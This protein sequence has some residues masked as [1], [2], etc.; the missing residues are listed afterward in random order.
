MSVEIY[1]KPTQEWF[2]GVGES[3]IFAAFLRRLMLLLLED[4]QQK[5]PKQPQAEHDHVFLQS[6]D[7][8]LTAEGEEQIAWP[9]DKPVPEALEKAMHEF[10]GAPALNAQRHVFNTGADARERGQNSTRQRHL[11]DLF[12]AASE[13]YVGRHPNHE[14][15]PHIRLWKKEVTVENGKVVESAIREV[16]RLDMSNHAI[17]RLPGINNIHSR[18]DKRD[19]FLH[20]TELMMG[21]DAIYTAPEKE[22][23]YSVYIVSY[24]YQNRMAFTADIHRY[25]ADASYVAPNIQQFVDEVLLPSFEI[26]EGT[27]R[28]VAGQLKTDFRHLTLLSHS[29][30]S[31]AALQMQQAMA[32]RMQELGYDAQTL[33]QALPA[34]YH[35]SIFPVHCIREDVPKAG[36]F[37][38]FY[39]AS[40]N[41]LNALSRANYLDLAPQTHR[42]AGNQVINA[43][44]MM[45]WMHA[46]IKGVDLTLRDKGDQQAYKTE[47]WGEMLQ[48]PYR[49]KQQGHAP[50]L[51]AHDV[52]T[53]DGKRFSNGIIRYAF[54]RGVERSDGAPDLVSEWAGKIRVKRTQNDDPERGTG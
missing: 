36:S 17:V 3:E 49:V 25:N 41:D 2:A 53:S 10:L 33:R 28:K 20:S 13:Y 45:R 5:V 14:R 11:S 31:V 4:E 32:N 48:L 24:P 9:Q 29:Y 54:K 22:G 38:H 7:A 8:F 52:Q 21:G 12:T 46:P 35:Q 51:G 44:S 30:G 15:N 47:Q 19:Y 40:S 50:E 42:G 39:V 16:D 18:A 1:G 43:H 23:R 26:D 37:S 27:P 34:I 6:V